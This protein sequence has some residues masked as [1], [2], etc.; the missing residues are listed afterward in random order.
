MLKLLIV[1]LGGFVGAIAR[2]GASRMIGQLAK[3]AFPLGTLAVNVTG[4]LL[5]G[6]LGVLFQD[7][8][9]H[10]LGLRYVVGVGDPEGHVDPARTFGEDVLHTTVGE[11][12]VGDDHLLVVQGD[13]DG[14]E[15]LDLPHPPEMA[16]GLD[17]VVYAEGLEDQ[18]QDAA[19]EVGEAALEGQTDGQAGGTENSDEGRCLNTQLPECGNNDKGQQGNIG[20]TADEADNNRIDIRLLHHAAHAG[21]DALRDP[22]ANNE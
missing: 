20:N 13:Q 12:R 4:C 17:D 18:D 11:Q 22:A 5:I 7:I 2:Y 10:L 19:R 21:T 15:D 16:L 6:C 8:G 1:G 14:V 3:G 9:Q